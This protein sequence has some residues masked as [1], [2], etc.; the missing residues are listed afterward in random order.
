[1]V[2]VDGG[3]VEHQC[4]DPSLLFDVVRNSERESVTGWEWQISDTV[5]DV[6]EISRGHNQI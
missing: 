1:M 2:T 4:K 3:G 6:S 5:Q